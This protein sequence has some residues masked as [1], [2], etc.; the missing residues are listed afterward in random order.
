[1]LAVFLPGPAKVVSSSTSSRCYNDNKCRGE[2]YGHLGA[3]LNKSANS[4][5]LIMHPD[6]S[7]FLKTELSRLRA[8]FAKSGTIQ[9]T[10]ISVN[11]YLSYD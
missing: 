5:R 3:S 4:R 8:V 1:V 6:G 11:D 9:M 2:N 7:F 10:T